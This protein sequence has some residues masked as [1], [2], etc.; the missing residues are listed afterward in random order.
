V[1]D[2]EDAGRVGRER[3]DSFRCV[4]P[5]DG[6][7]AGPKVVVLG[8]VIVVKVELG[9]ARLEELEGFVDA[10]VL[11]GL[12]EVGVAYVETDADA[13]EVADAEDLEDVLGSGD[14][15]L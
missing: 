1:G 11:F 5:V 14:V 12:G 9:D 13:V 2:L 3:G 7:G 6:C 4:G 15:V 10:D 8:A